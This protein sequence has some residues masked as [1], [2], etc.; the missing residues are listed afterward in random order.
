MAVRNKTY[1]TYHSDFTKEQK[2]DDVRLV[3]QIIDWKARDEEHVNFINAMEKATAI[4]DEE[5]Q[6]PLVRAI[7]NRLA[8]STNFIL[9]MGAVVKETT[10]WVKFEIE[11]AVDHSTLPVIATYI[12][13]ESILTPEKLE[14]H[15]PPALDMRIKNGSAQVVH[16]PFKE[17][18]LAR[19]VGQFVHDNLPK[20][21]L[22][23]YTKGAYD[24]WGLELRGT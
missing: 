2:A 5:K 12:G 1:I 24:R 15:W 3:R 22:S 23:T 4:A 18:P 14:H 11:W 13:Y 19:A 8:A 9:I 16:I 7:K 6:L 20:G 17:D 10:P 21:G